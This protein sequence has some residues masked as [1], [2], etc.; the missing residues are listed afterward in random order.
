MEALL[1]YRIMMIMAL[2]LATSAALQQARETTFTR[3]LIIVVSADTVAAANAQAKTLDK[4]LAETGDQTF[5]V[6]L[7]ATGQEPATHYWCSWVVQPDD[8]NALKNRLKSL[9]LV[10]KAKIFDGHKLTP[11]DVLQEMGLKVI[12]P[13][14]SSDAGEVRN[15]RKAGRK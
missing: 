7:S 3:R 4:R 9:S 12:A 6:G 10:G 1:I 15:L 5:S 2:I 8:D 11:E 13:H 14:L